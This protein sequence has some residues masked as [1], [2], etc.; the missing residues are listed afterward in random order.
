MDIVKEGLE[1]LGNRRK[2]NHSDDS[3]SPLESPLTRALENPAFKK[4]FFEYESSMFTKAHT[5]I[6]NIVRKRRG[7]EVRFDNLSSRVLGSMKNLTFNT[8]EKRNLFREQFIKELK[9]FLK[10][11]SE[12]KKRKI[13]YNRMLRLSEELSQS[14]EKPA[15]YGELEHLPVK[16][17]YSSFE[18]EIKI[19][20]T[21]YR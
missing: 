19:P 14:P 16:G 6:K 11:F 17:G 12:T 8:G 7:R 15:G 1:R 20:F 5:S 3:E 2:E 9:R 18:K 10:Y 21:R 13:L 4:S